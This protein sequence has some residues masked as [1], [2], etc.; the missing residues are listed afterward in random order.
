MTGP[1]AKPLENQEVSKEKPKK[2]WGKGPIRI[3]DV[4]LDCYILEDGMAVLNKGKMMKAIGRKWK[5]RSRTDRPNFIGAVN[6]QP[7]I[8]PELEEKLKGISFYDGGKLIAG[9]HADILPL[10]CNVYLEARTAQVLSDSQ[11]PKKGQEKTDI[12]LY[13]I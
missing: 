12:I 1:L 7:F 2:I 6:L 9:Y 4:D 5:G 8:R 11:Q 13:L 10:V 3:Y